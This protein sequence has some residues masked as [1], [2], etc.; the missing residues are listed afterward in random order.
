MRLF[1]VNKTRIIFFVLGI[2]ILILLF[3]SFGVETFIKDI[4]LLGWKFILIVS[5]FLFNNVILSY[6]WKVLINYPLKWKLFHRLLLARIAGDSTSSINSMGA[7]AGEPIKALL[8]KDYIP[9]NK[10]LASV[11]LDRTVHTLANTLLI[12]T[13][14]ISSFF[15]LK[16]PVLISTGFLLFII[17]VLCAIIYILRKQKQGF[18]RFLVKK[19][20]K[21]LSSRFMN[22]ERQKK[23]DELDSEIG[24]IL[25]SR[26]NL[27]RFYISLVFRYISILATGTL[28]VFMILIFIDIDISLVNSMFVYIFTLFL[29]SIVFFMPANIGTSEA[30]YSLALNFLGYDPALG[31]SVGIIRRLRTFIWSGIGMI[32][33]FYSGVVNKSEDVGNE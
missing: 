8:M 17:F 24:F 7:V 19:L 20:P 15:V 27:K 9:F 4:R 5:L 25:N 30:S 11:V 3:K 29:T 32:I 13:G 6:S 28:E 10:G 21:K 1:K 14:V 12:L 22:S 23:I 16:L 31:L 33:L 18:I 26:E 2:L